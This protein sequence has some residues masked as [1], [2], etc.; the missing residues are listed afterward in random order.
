MIQISSHFPPAL[1]VMRNNGFDSVGKAAD[2]CL[3]RF[4]CEV[5]MWKSLKYTEQEEEEEVWIGRRKKQ[6]FCCLF[7]FPIEKF[8]GDLI[9]I[10]EHGLSILHEIPHMHEGPILQSSNFT[11]TLIEISTTTAVWKIFFS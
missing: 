10:F 5:W 7:C 2:L 4:V 1:F 8:L 6:I 9:L 11:F 3:R